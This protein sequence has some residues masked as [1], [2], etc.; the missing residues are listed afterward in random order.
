MKS[1]KTKLMI[2]F[3][4]LI[5][6]ISG[7]L[8]LSAFMNSAKALKNN[9]DVSLPEIA[10]QTASS[11]QGRLEGQL[12]VLDSISARKEISDPNI[13]LE[14][15]LKSLQ[16][17]V[18][19]IGSV[20]L[21]IATMDGKLTNTDGTIADIKE[22]EYYK[23]CIEGKDAVGE[24]IVLKDENI[25]VVP[26]AVPIKNDGEVIGVLIGTRDG[27]ALS[28][29]TNQVKVGKDGSAFMIGKDGTSIANVDKDRV[30]KMSNTIE[31]AK[32]DD[33]LQ[34][35][36][37]VEKKMING[38]TGAGEVYYGGKY[39]YI[40]YAPVKGT[41]WY[42]GITVP[43][44]EI[45]SQLDDLKIFNI[46][47]SLVAIFIGIFIIYLISNTITKALKITSEHLSMLA[48]GDLTQNVS[49]RYLKLKDEIGEMTMSMKVM[50]QSLKEM[51]IKIK[52]NSL[53]I[54]NQSE[55]LSSVSEEIA[56]SS[57]NVTESISQI[58]EGTGNQSTELVNITEIF[59]EFNNNLSG[60]VGDIQV[61]DSSTRE[62]NKMAISSNSEMNVLNESVM[63]VSQSFKE[64][65]RKIK[66]LG[67]SVNK[68]NEITELINAV[69]EQTNLLALNASI[70]AARAGEAG[71]G[72]SVV[73]MEIG[74]LA[75]K[76]K[77]SV[78]NIN[79]LT[80]EISRDTNIIVEDSINMDNELMN[81]VKIIDNSISSFKNII[82]AVEEMMP[83]VD[84][85]KKSA[86][87]IEEEKDSILTKVDNISSISMEVS[88]S[89]EEIS[90]SSEEMNAS[91]EE[92]AA[93]SQILYNSTRQMIGAV[94][95]F[96][97]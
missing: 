81:Q 8:N 56:S 23:E 49:T 11:I 68:I 54:N 79:K 57:Q 3:G 2:V 12:N 10:V 61:T 97:I 33:T 36:A 51:I 64:F 1:I 75:E 43:K 14:D 5:V 38:E 37:D 73:A 70:E 29:L 42:V 88:A 53:N 52:D 72:F 76:S 13:S 85:V 46:V 91:T 59:E 69:S 31:E 65:Y 48:K 89:A 66:E 17:D 50:Q 9:V 55:S 47:S 20:R 7:S 84:T 95:K 34:E 16:D 25:Q 44:E 4:V 94:E 35:L 30:L 18:R 6:V 27:Q 40:G 41:N 19:R 80:T 22:R 71:K 24:P 32:K 63:S 96:K 78:S 58:A 87:K 28:D 86:E 15:K 39:K 93:A 77:E 62:I 45:L 21:G 26:Y 60:M 74:K 67:I 90:A 82:T 83:K 92:V